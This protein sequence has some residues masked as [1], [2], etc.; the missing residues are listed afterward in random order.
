VAAGN[1]PKILQ[2]HSYFNGTIYVLDF[3][4]YI[5]TN[6]IKIHIELENKREERK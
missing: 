4:S 6:N 5:E 3:N 1:F 2:V